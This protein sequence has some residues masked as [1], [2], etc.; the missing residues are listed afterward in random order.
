MYLFALWT[1]MVSNIYNIV[2][3]FS[4]Q[5][6]Y[7]LLISFYGWSF[8]LPPDTLTRLNCMCCWLEKKID[9]NCSTHLIEII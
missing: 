9:I 7:V 3:Q 2:N 6:V 5:W 4:Q 1:L 8:N